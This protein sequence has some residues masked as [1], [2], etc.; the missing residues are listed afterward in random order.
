MYQFCNKGEEAV[1]SLNI[2]LQ[3]HSF[4]RNYNETAGWSPRAL[5]QSTI[6]RSNVLLPFP[7][8]QAE[9]SLP[10]LLEKENEEGRL[11]AA[12][13]SNWSFLLLPSFPLLFFSSSWGLRFLPGPSAPG[14]EWMGQGHLWGWAFA[15]QAQEFGY[16]PE[17]GVQIK[18]FTKCAESQV[19]V[20]VKGNTEIQKG[21][22]RGWE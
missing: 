7:L 13:L 2:H 17:E 3:N 15:P 4:E 9:L 5:F 22:S 16:T 10:I 8:F 19:S 11:V 1:F 20:S 21:E 12:K 14:W 6:Q 18:K